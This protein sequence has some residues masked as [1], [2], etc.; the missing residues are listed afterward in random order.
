M[1]EVTFVCQTYF[2]L[3]NDAEIC[4]AKNDMDEAA[5]IHGKLQHFTYIKVVTFA[6]IHASFIG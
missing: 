3:A 2:Y 1:L 4:M 5:T 6:L